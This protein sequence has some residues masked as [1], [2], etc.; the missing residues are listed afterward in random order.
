MKKEKMNYPFTS[1]VGQEAMKEVLILNL[2]SP[3][4]GGVLIRGEKGTSILFLVDASRSMGARKKMTTV[5]GAILSLL[6][7][8]YQKR[9]SV[10]MMV[11]YSDVVELLLPPTRSVD[12]AYHKLKESPV[13]GKTPLA[14]GLSRSLE[15]MTGMG[16]RS[17]ECDA[18]IVLISD[19]RANIPLKGENALDNVLEIAKFSQGMPVRFVVVDTETGFPRIGLADKVAKALAGSYFKLEELDAEKLA[20]SVHTTI[21]GSMHSSAHYKESPIGGY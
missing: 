10:G 1:I 12:L 14:L 20:T 21:H 19:C 2:I 8:A 18:V 3:G 13:G 16:I 7:D 6:K 9:D 15:L 17:H 11:F 5:K 4:I